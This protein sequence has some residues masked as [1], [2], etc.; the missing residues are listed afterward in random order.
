MKATLKIILVSLMLLT[1]GIQTVFLVDA[2][3]LTILFDDLH[4]VM[5]SDNIN[6]VNRTFTIVDNPDCD[7]A[8]ITT[9]IH[10]DNK[11]MIATINMNKEGSIINQHDLDNIYN[12]S[13]EGRSVAYGVVIETTINTYYFTYANGTAYIWNSITDDFAVK[14]AQISVIMNLSRSDEQI[15]SS[16]GFCY[17]IRNDSLN[18]LQMF[19]DFV[20]NDLIISAGFDSDMSYIVDEEIT[21]SAYVLDDYNIAEKPYYFEWD[22]GDGYIENGQNVSHIYNSPGVYTV[23][24]F[25]MDSANHYSYYEKI[26][27]VNKPTFNR[28]QV[29]WNKRVDSHDLYVSMFI[30][31]KEWHIKEYSIISPTGSILTEVTTELTWVDDYTHGRDSSRGKDTL[32]VALQ[33]EMEYT[34]EDS[35]GSGT[36]TFSNQIYETPDD[37]IVYADTE[38][39]A[40]QKVDSMVS[41]KNN[42]YFHMEIFISPGEKI[43]QFFKY[44]KDKGNPIDL[45]ASFAYYEYD[46]EFIND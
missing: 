32:T 12:P 43:F 41:G 1:I 37:F 4:D 13:N 2:D 28:Y 29:T 27:D 17:D 18:G 31:R 34:S 40:K 3:S 30:P 15:V 26:I 14:D 45:S 21:F 46:I 7:I 5:M 19:V 23:K 25:F 8:N 16:A 22:F 10:S 24:L 36:H 35:T 9:Y 38:F 33:R 11:K 6:D 44:L 39:E 42:A 20:P